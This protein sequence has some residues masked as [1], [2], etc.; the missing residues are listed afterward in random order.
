MDNGFWFRSGTLLTGSTLIL[1]TDQKDTSGRV[2][3][4][5]TRAVHPPQVGHFQVGDFDFTLI[6]VH[7]TFA[8]GD[9]T[10]SIREL[11]GVLD[12]L[13]WY[14]NQPDHDPDVIVCGDFNTPSLLSGQQGR[15]WI[16]LDAVFD[17]DLRFQVG[18]RRFVVTVHQPTSRN[19]SGTPVSNYDHCVLSADTMEEF[20]GARRVST[21]ILTDH[22][23]DPEVR[24]TSD[25][26]PVVAF[27][28]TRGDG[29]AP[30]LRTRIK[31]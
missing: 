25:H 17:Q 23:D 30:D 6:T 2:V 21:T 12:Y 3:T 16:T 9:T 10:E 8:D 20:V 24:L 1:T 14:F 13:D 26:F 19:S 11:R 22:P 31:P 15:N 4:D 5:P 27:F 29:V 7:L 28:R 18:E